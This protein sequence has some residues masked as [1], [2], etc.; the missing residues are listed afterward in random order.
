MGKTGSLPVS[1]QREE[2]NHTN[3]LLREIHERSFVI[4]CISLKANSKQLIAKIKTFRL[5]IWMLFL[6]TYFTV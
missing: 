3:V 1:S 5:N 6:P 4:D 2:S